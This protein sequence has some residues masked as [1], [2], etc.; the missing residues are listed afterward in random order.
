MFNVGG[1]EMLVIM[2]VALIVLG[3]NKLPDAARQAG[4]WM[5]EFRKISTGFQREMRDAMNQ[6]SDPLD[7]GSSGSSGPTVGSSN[8]STAKGSPSSGGPSNGSAPKAV[9]P[10]LDKTADLPAARPSLEKPGDASSADA[11]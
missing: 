11:S 6:I 3:P 10:T 2:V 5:G 4:K 7:L 8:G 9:G 1:A